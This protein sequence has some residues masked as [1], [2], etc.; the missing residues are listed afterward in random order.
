MC[1]ISNTRKKL[2]LNVQRCTCTRKLQIIK[3]LAKEHLQGYSFQMAVN[4]NVDQ[5]WKPPLRTWGQKTIRI[6]NG[7]IID[8]YL[9]KCLNFLQKWD[10]K[11]SCISQPVS[12]LC[13]KYLNHDAY[14]RGDLTKLYQIM[15]RSWIAYISEEL[16]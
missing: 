3:W 10:S 1:T 6:K 13:N 7:S 16:L 9:N 4:R 2:C 11:V 8:K 12:I 14:K 15:K 5:C